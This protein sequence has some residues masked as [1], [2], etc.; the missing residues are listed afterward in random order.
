MD[1]KTDKTHKDYLSHIQQADQFFSTEFNVNSKN[2]KYS[3]GDYRFSDTDGLV[4]FVITSQVTDKA[5]ALQQLDNIKKTQIALSSIATDYIAKYTDVHGKQFKTD[6]QFWSDVIAKLPLMSIQNIETQTYRHD[7][8]GFSIATNLLQLIMDI[9]LTTHS[10]GM[11]SFANFLQKQGDAIRMG[12]EQNDDYYST[13]TLAS[14]IEAVGMDGQI[15]YIPKI[16]LYKIDFDRSN[17]E[18]T[19][20]CASNKSVNVEFTY[21]SCVALFDYQALEDPQIKTSFDNF[22]LKHRT[23]SIEDSDSFFSGEFKPSSD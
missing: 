22:I 19:S 7:M 5:H 1:I 12:L 21:S 14:V 8:I 10:P 18:M 23:S 20:N 17:S 16:K 13:L 4:Q 3:L 11:K 15:I 2:G 9:V 6:I